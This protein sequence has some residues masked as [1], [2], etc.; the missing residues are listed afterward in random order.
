MIVGVV[1]LAIKFTEYYEHYQM[2]KV[3]GFWFESDK[4]QAAHIAMFYVFYFVMTGLH[5]VHM[6]IGIGLLSV[7]LLRAALG[8][9]SAEYHTPVEVVGLYWHFVDI[10]WIFLF[11]FLYLIPGP[12]NG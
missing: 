8:S 4:P 1:F 12:H 6:M 7:I 2:H 3:P 5:A 11:P 10:V 9:F